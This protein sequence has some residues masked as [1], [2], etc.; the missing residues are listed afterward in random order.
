MRGVDYRQAVGCLLW[1]ANGTRPD[2]AYAVSQVS[3]FLEKSGPKHWQAVKRIVRYLS[4]SGDLKIR[5]THNSEDQNF[6]EGYFSGILPGVMTSYVDADYATCKETRRSVT[7]YIFLLAGG[8]VSWNSGKQPSVALST[9][10]AEYM[11]AA[12]AVQELVWLKQL[13]IQLSLKVPRTMTLYEDNQSTIFLADGQG[14][15]QR[16]KHIDVKYRYVQEHIKSQEV[17]LEYIRSQFNLADIL[18]KA[19]VLTVFSFLAAQ[20]LTR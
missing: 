9:T 14:E 19:L 4:G 7:G 16:S 20:L 8:P 15:H 6:T 10:E 18:T 5:Y 2:I 11:A 3:R 17:H 12:S 13:Q 1:I